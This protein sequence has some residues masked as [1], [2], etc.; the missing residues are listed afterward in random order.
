[1]SILE[2]I[3]NLLSPVEKKSIQE[4]IADD[5]GQIRTDTPTKKDRKL[6]EWK[7]D[8]D[9][10]IDIID[11]SPNLYLVHRAARVCV[12][13]GPLQGTEAKVAHLTK[14]VKLG[15]ESILEHSNIIAHVRIPKNTLCLMGFDAVVGLIDLLG[16]SKFL[17]ICTNNNS[18]ENIDILI[19][20]SIRGYLHVLRESDQDSKMIYIIQNIMSQTIEKFFLQ[21]MID[22]ELIDESEC[23][24]L[25]HGEL[26]D[27]DINDD[28][29]S[30]ESHS[31]IEPKEIPGKR[32]DLV[33]AQNI[34]EIATKVASY[35][36]DIKDVC[37][38]CTIS[39]LFHDIS[40]SCANQMTRHRV[41]ISQESQRYCKHSTNS[42]SDFINPMFLVADRYQ[43]IDQQVWNRVKKEN[44]FDTY[45]YLMD[46]G[47]MKEDARAWL[48]MNVTTKLMMTFTYSQLFHFYK[49]RSEKG[50][51]KEVQLVAEELRSFIDKTIDTSS[52]TSI[53]DLIEACLAY[54]SSANLKKYEL[55]SVD[56]TEI[57]DEIKPIKIDSLKDAED[58]MKANEEYK[59]L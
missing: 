2:S 44:P 54:R 55:Q 1:M 25:P 59:N 39:F 58:Y 56:E 28:N 53:D 10:E 51:Q 5:V 35:G 18:E 30:T 52:I 24:Y 21:D 16:K 22:R 8:K 17:N 34:N 33:Y 7:W 50:A 9:I 27:F 12:G 36:F 38:V 6:P 31:L 46:N 32:M 57:V 26:S 47:I 4:K 23:N 13:K 15:H 14:L 42:S 19:G 3:K 48:P 43:N 45:N 11:I 49:I 29:A 40:R 41:G 37:Q 20:G